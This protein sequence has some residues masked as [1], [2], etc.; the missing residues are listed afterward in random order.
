MKLPKFV[1]DLTQIRFD[2]ENDEARA[3]H[4]TRVI[5]FLMGFTLLI[6]SPIVLFVILSDPE[7]IAWYGIIMLAIL[8]IPVYAAWILVRFGRWKLAGTLLNFLFLALGFFGVYA[9]NIGTTF[10]LFFILAVILS[11]Y[12]YSRLTQLIIIIISIVGTFSISWITVHDWELTLTAGI[13]FSGLLIGIWLLLLMGNNLLEKSLDYHKQ[14]TNQLRI[15][16]FERKTAELSIAENNI[17]LEKRVAN[18]TRQLITANQEL[19]QVAYSIA[20]DLRAPI[21]AII[22]FNEIIATEYAAKLDPEITGYLE[23]SIK[24]GRKTDSM[25]EELLYLL[26]LR[27][28]ELNRSNIDLGAEAIRVF[29]EL[30]H[31][32]ISL[33]IHETPPAEADLSLVTELLTQ[34]I[35]NAITY[36]G[37]GNSKQIEFGSLRDHKK[38]IYFLSDNGIGINMNY[39]DKIFDP[40]VNLAEPDKSEGNGIGLTIARRIIELHQGNI[41]VESKKGEGS[42]FFFTL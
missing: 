3:E 13:T 1:Y 19:Y 36:S 28:V 22:G 26:S 2:L 39:A 34:L 9:Y 11:G 15:E 17:S 31:Q 37:N 23:K 35:S 7:Q 40:F 6:F 38:A 14:L 24:A 18:R 29:N 21:R 20:H 10:L 12:Y 16:V 42:T 33:T 27:N 5:L 25:L 8:N 41:W 30:E 4:I 32:E